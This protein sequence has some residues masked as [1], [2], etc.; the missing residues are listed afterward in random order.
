MRARPKVK[1]LELLNQDT[2]FINVDRLL[3]MDLFLKSTSE[4]SV[5]VTSS[6]GIGVGDMIKELASSRSLRDQLSCLQSRKAHFKVNVFG[7]AYRFIIILKQCCYRTYLIIIHENQTIRWNYLA[8]QIV[9]LFGP[10]KKP[11]E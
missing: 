6:D 3:S 4:I 5:V 9:V 7:L 11:E 8:M 10:S 2:V 1:A